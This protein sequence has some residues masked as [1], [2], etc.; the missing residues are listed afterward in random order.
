MVRG[1]GAAFAP[2]RF[3][4]AG[5]HGVSR[6]PGSVGRVSRVSGIVDVSGWEVVAIEPGGRDEKAWLREPGT[7]A[8]WLFKPVVTH[9]DR[10]Q[11]ED[12]AEKIVAR[13]ADLLGVPAARIELA[14]RREGDKAR[15]G[16]ISCDVRPDGWESHTGA[17]L[18][19]EIVQDFAVRSADRRG[20]P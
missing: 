8:R 12:W 6:L 19:G 7:D 10:R 13:V 17:V 20:T 1:A 11:G 2:V 4:L 3:G 9:V 18:L 5:C 15:E 16:C 14:Q